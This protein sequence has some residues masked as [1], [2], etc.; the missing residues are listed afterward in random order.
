MFAR[1]GIVTAAMLA[2]CQVGWADEVPVETA[3]LGASAITLHLHPF[4]TEEE[5]ATLR[6]VAV[7]EQALSLFVPGNAGFAALAVSPKD[8]FIRDGA[9]VVSAVALA[10]L[11][12]QAT[13]SLK[14][15]EACNAAKTGAA[16][17]VTVLEIAPA[18]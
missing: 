9:L 2:F 15:V 4:L 7:N 3:T 14:A 13:A 12:D 5:T 8:G 18:P 1:S 16:D 10:G 11:P 17:C 6:L